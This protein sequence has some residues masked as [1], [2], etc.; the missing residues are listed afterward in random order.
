MMWHD[1]LLFATLTVLVAVVAAATVTGLVRRFVLAR[2]MIDVPNA[3]SSHVEPTARGGGLAI[4]TVV[5]AGVSWSWVRGEMEAPLALGLI[6]GGGMVAG[7]GLLDD[8]GHV[9]A[10]RRLLV[11]V[12]A[13][14]G[15]LAGVGGLPEVQWGSASVDL[16]LAGDMLAGL[17]CVWFLNLFNFMDGIDGIAASEAAWIAFAAAGL[18][19][20]TD[21]PRALVSVWL[22]IGAASL[23]FLTWNWPPARIFMGD[24]GSGFLGFALALLLVYSTGCSGLTVWTAIIL[25]SPFIADATVTLVV[26]VT[27]GERWYSAHRSHAYQRLSRQWG[28]HAK[29]TGLFL[30]VNVVLVLPAAFGSVFRPE[31]GPSIAL[32]LLLALGG[33]ARAAGAGRAEPT[34]DVS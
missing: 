3:R 2:G 34:R 27:R 28:S 33:A 6:L 24:V 19:S 5:L 16:G 10:P 22:L 8:L 11:H 18:A 15:A 12:I 21:A 4:V 30:A 17:A 31:H 26:R 14:G 1:E 25:A 29:V 9:P 7:I 20:L 23:G 13:L 32:T